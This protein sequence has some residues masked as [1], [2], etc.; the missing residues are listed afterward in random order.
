[1]P[2]IKAIAISSDIYKPASPCGFCRQMIREF[3]DEDTPIFM[4]GRAN[5]DGQDYT[6]ISDEEELKIC[7]KPVVSTIGILLPLSFGPNG[8]FCYR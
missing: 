8:T 5:D 6:N 1:M 7:G 2:K 3:S 4:Y